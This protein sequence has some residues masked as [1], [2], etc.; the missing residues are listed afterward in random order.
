MAK[1]AKATTV[2]PKEGF[3]KAFDILKQAKIDVL[4]VLDDKLH[5]TVGITVGVGLDNLI[6]RLSHLTGML[7]NYSMQIQTDFPPITE[8]M[9]E[10]LEFAKDI[11]AEDLSPKELEKKRFNEKIDRL[12]AALPN[13]S[14]D[15]IIEDQETLVIRGLAKRAGLENFRNGEVDHQFINDIRA[16]L[17][18]ESYQESRKKEQEA[19]INK[20]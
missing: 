20:A 18:S 13:M 4:A 5:G 9:G 15:L 10:K 6:N 12:E 8:F 2:N 14:N 11:K 3:Q 17:T 1:S 7:D 16:Q 19:A